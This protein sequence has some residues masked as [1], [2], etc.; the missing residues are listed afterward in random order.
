MKMYSYID[1]PYPLP[2]IFGSYYITDQF[3]AQLNKILT[4]IYPDYNKPDI[5]EPEQIVTLIYNEQIP[6]RARCIIGLGGLA[7]LRPGEICGLR[8]EKIDFN[9]KIINIDLQYSQGVLK[10][11]KGKKKR[12]VPILPDLE[13]ILKEWYIQ[14]GHGKFLFESKRGNPL[15]LSTWLRKDYRPALEL[16]KLPYVKPHSLR[17]AFSKMLS[18][19][20]VPP[21]EK[22]Q[23]MGHSSK[24]MSFEVYDR[25]S[26]KRMV[27]V[28]RFQVFS[29]GFLRNNL[30][31]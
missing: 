29:N 11:P 20:G 15:A 17:H 13:P 27:K 31:K 22:M 25:E 23:I 18:D 2:K 9:E 7:G 4:T 3:A 10:P 21:R 12:H 5:L 30:R 24:K 28:T 8:K 16:A 6:L 26:V 14:S 19:Y 1:L